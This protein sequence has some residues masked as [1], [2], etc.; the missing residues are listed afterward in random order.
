MLLIFS[1]QFKK[2]LFFYRF[3]KLISIMT[4][5]HNYKIIPK[6]NAKRPHQAENS[7]VEPKKRRSSSQSNQNDLINQNETYSSENYDQGLHDSDDE[8]QLERPV[9]NSLDVAATVKSV[10]D[11]QIEDNVLALITKRHNQEI[12]RDQQ[13]MLQDLI[14]YNHILEK[15]L[16]MRRKILEEEEEIEKAFNE[17]IQRKQSILRDSH[18]RH[19][20]NVS[21]KKNMLDSLKQK[22]EQLER[23]KSLKL[24]EEARMLRKL[25]VENEMIKNQIKEI[26][27]AVASPEALK[28]IEIMQQ[29]EKTLVSSQVINIH[30]C[31]KLNL[32][33][34]QSL[35][36]LEKIVEEESRAKTEKSQHKSNITTTIIK[37]TDNIS[38]K[39]IE[40]RT[41][42]ECTQKYIESLKNMEKTKETCK[43]LNTDAKHKKYR[44]ELTAAVGRLISTLNS[45]QM[46]PFKDILSLLNGQSVIS[47]GNKLVS[48]GAHTSA[49]HFCVDKLAKKIVEQ[50]TESSKQNSALY[51]KLALHL[52]S[53]YPLFSSLLKAHLALISPISVP[54]N[55]AKTKNEAEYFAAQGYKMD[56]NGCLEDENKFLSRQ[57]SYM[58]FYA[59]LMLSGSDNSWCMAQIWKWLARLLNQQP[60]EGISATALYRVLFQAERKLL[61]CYQRQY[62]KILKFIKEDYMN[63]IERVTGVGKKGP[64]V[65]LRTFVENSLRND[66]L[67]GN[68]WFIIK[69]FF[70][71]FFLFHNEFWFFYWSF[72]RFL[73]YMN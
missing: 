41:K 24:E 39:D 3:G 21:N 17:E 32:L 33:Y 45:Q 48:I 49:F 62:I 23:E 16:M 19:A 57:S 46:S 54:F 52:S 47:S 44:F 11:Q 43:E 51:V 31:S 40:V 34:K 73:F 26:I 6:F 36:H 67:S 8:I 59:D 60:S 29:Q 38:H 35:M 1:V 18:L 20:Q 55:P 28:T 65:R 70:E 10:L 37:K 15:D 56:D 50:A 66:G 13:R 4:S 25:Q 5:L 7:K 68:N 9:L 22:K 69:L 14:L 53:S 12:E 42:T 2:D 30:V 71:I 61:K 63:K 27:N 72:T 58:T 64:V